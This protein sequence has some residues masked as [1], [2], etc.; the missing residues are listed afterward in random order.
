MRCRR[1]RHQLISSWLPTSSRS[2]STA[3][4][5]D[6]PT[7]L[8][9]PQ[10]SSASDLAQN[11][12]RP[13]F[14]T[15][16]PEFW[17]QR[18][19]LSLASWFRDYMYIPLGGSRVSRF[20]H[21][22]NVLAVFLVSGLWHGAN[23]TFVVWG[24]LNGIYQVVSL[25]TRPIRQRLTDLVALP[26][27]LGGHLRGL[28]TF[29]LILVTWVFFRAASLSDATTVLSRIAT[30]LPDLPR[31]LRVRISDLDI[32]LSLIVVGVL[33]GVEALEERRSLWER[34]ATRPTYERWAVYYAVLL[35]LVVFGTWNLN[36]F[37]YMQF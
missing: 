2:S 15:S 9:V 21:Y 5:R 13:Y 37:V 24:G 23:W 1:S 18:W 28:L 36:Q 26:P 35:M 12:R 27:R 7:W 33:L 16:V 30:S 20:R 3:T 34:L 17:A 11:F 31:L 29:H 14:S 10:R 32:V 8:S 19:H 6:T 25:I 4:S 22:A